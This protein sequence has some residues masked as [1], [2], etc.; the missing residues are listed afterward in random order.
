[1]KETLSKLLFEIL[2]FKELVELDIQ[3]GLITASPS[4]QARSSSRRGGG[5]ALLAGRGGGAGI[6]TT[7]GSPDGSGASK[8]YWKQRDGV[9]ISILSVL[10]SLYWDEGVAQPAHVKPGETKL[11]RTSDVLLIAQ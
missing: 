7:E 3:P 6:L 4:L 10:L 8:W 2:G 11:P 5:G 1:M 9:Q